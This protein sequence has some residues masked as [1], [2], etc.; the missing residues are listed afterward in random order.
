MNILTIDTATDYELISITTGKGTFEFA[1][2]V[3]MSHS[4]TIFS[5]LNSILERAELT[6]K[7]INLAGV[8]I[9]PGSFTGVRIAVSTARM[10][11]QILDIP[12]VGVKTQDIFVSSAGGNRGEKI[13]V[14]FDAKKSRVFGALYDGSSSFLHDTI[15]EAGDYTINSMLKSLSSGDRLLCIGDG[16]ARY[17]EEIAEIS[18]STGFSYRL[19]DNFTPDGAITSKLILHRYNESPD[20]YS[21][22]GNTLPFYARKSDAEAARDE[23]KPVT[24]G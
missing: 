12:L 17:R 9:G 14:A 13:L 19:A 23:R 7:D 1:R 2:D 22:Y 5:S 16:C 24:E 3:K 8:G 18:A 15:I 20:K 4:I 10:I 11:A 6:I 21:S